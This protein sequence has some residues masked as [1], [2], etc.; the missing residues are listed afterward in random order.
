MACRVV[1]QQ[2]FGFV[3][4]GCM[5]EGVGGVFCFFPC[6]VAWR[7]RGVVWAVG[8]WAELGLATGSLLYVD[9]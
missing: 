1:C 6:G 8:A 4:W 5:G 2:H 9:G 7:Y 3:G